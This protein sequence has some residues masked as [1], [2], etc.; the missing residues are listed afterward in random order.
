MEMRN[1]LINKQGIFLVFLLVGTMITVS[2]VKQSKL[3]LLES[4][5]SSGTSI[6]YWNIERDV[7]D[8]EKLKFYYL[9]NKPEALLT[10]ATDGKIGI[11]NVAPNANLVIGR[12]WMNAAHR[13]AIRLANAGYANPSAPGS[14]SNGDKLLF[15]DDNRFKVGM[16]FAPDNSLWFQMNTTGAAIRFFTGPESSLPEERMTITWDGK[17]GIGTNAPGGDAL[18]VRGR[19]YA[20]G[21]WQSSDADYAEWFEKEETTK[22]GDIIGTNMQTG[23]VRKYRP[24]DH[25]VGIHSAQPAVVGNRVEE[26][27]EEME[28]RYT[29]VGILGQLEFDRSQVSLNGRMVTTRDGKEI[30]VLLSNNKVL[31]GR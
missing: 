11:D 4:F 21:G 15:W 17:V 12:D 30:G 13:T 10:L 22:V 16:G 28:K 24:G 3:S 19:A 20:S 25:F 31:V 26:N 9:E 7:N 23:K 14:T 8:S 29:L 27:N 5:A 1:F 6:P 18:D 2:V